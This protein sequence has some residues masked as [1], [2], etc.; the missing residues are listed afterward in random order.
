MP[1]FA[2]VRWL[3][4]ESVGVMPLSAVKKDSNACVGAIVEMKFKKKIL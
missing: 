1:Q 4:D 2:L 3:E